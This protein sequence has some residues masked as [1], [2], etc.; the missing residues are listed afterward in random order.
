M[1]T[2]SVGRRLVYR[3]G[4]PVA[5][6]ILPV[7]R[8]EEDGVIDPRRQGRVLV[9]GSVNVDLVARAERLPNPGETV[10]GAEFYRAGGGKGANQ[11]VAAARASHS[12]VVFVAAVGDD[13]FGRESLAA[14][15]REGIDTRWIKSLEGVPTGVAMILVDSRGQNLISVASGANARVRADDIDQLPELLFEQSA[16]ALVSLETPFD[17]V[18][19]FLR[20]ARRG[21]CLTVL[22]PAPM[23]RLI[24]DE[25]TLGLVDI[26]TPNETEAQGLAQLLGSGSSSL[27]EAVQPIRSLGCGSV[28][29]TLGSEGVLMVDG[30][31]ASPREIHVPARPVVAVDATGAG[32]AFNGALAVALA[33]GRPLTQAVEWAVKA[34]ARSVTRRGAQP[35]LATRDEIEA[36]S[37]GG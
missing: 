25:G 30:P 2:V 31:V 32:D 36:D 23:N 29:V 18:R 3:E 13:E 15:Q 7:I 22:N 33:E 21:G 16:V 24:V 10:L 27:D 4:E 28:V 6:K 17:A 14:F 37:L 5:I 19:C 1:V 12:S 8:A 9:L 35:S 34:A 26:L 11:A 20:R